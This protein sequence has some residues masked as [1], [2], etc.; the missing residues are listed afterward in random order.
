M[1]RIIIWFCSSTTRPWRSANRCRPGKRPLKF[2]DSNAGPKRLVA[3]A[4]FGGSLQIAQN[5][6]DDKERLKKVVNGVKFSSVSPNGDIASV[7]VPH[8]GA[9][10]GARDVLLALRS[11]AKDLSSVPGR[12]TLIFLSAGFALDSELRSDLTAVIDVCNKANVAVYPIDVRG[13]VALTKLDRPKDRRL[14][15]TPYPMARSSRPLLTCSG[16]RVDLPGAAVEHEEA[17]RVEVR[18]ERVVRAE[19]ARG[20]WVA[21]AELA[22]SVDL[23]RESA[24]LE[25][26]RILSISR[27]RLCRT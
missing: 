20:E 7:G 12:K 9:A 11:L 6:T 14:A 22:V 18:D 4:N 21:R 27:A 25:T 23:A 15:L 10:F 1:L 24:V 13:L 3:I 2:L 16:V 5:F 19:A 8:L 26:S 17:L